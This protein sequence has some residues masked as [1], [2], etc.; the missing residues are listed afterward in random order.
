MLIIDAN[1]FIRCLDLRSFAEKY[2]IYTTENVLTEIKDKRAREQF[3]TIPFEIKTISANNDA[4]DKGNKIIFCL[5]IGIPN[6]HGSYS[7]LYEGI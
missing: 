3:L 5:N 7:F 6:A 1:A 2:E 4:Y